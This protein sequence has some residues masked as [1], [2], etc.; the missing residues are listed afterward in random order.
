M[1]SRILAALA[2]R[3]SVVGLAVDDRVNGIT[4]K[5]H[6]H[7]QFDSASV[8]K[9]TILSALLR[10]LQQ[11]HRGLTAAQRKLATAMITVSDN[12]AASTLWAETGRPSLQH[13][14]DLAGMTETVLGPGGYWGLTLI[15]AHD[16][17]TLL[18]LLTSTN[19]VL[20]TAS[21]DYVLGL[22]AR[23]VSY[24]RW[25]VP[26]GAPTDVTVHVK[27]GWLPLPTHGWRINSIGSFSGPGKDY[28]IVVL[29]DDNPTMAYGVDTV[30][31]RRR[32]D[33]P[34]AEPRRGL[35]HPRRHAERLVGHSPTSRSRRRSGRIVSI[36]ADTRAAARAAF[37]DWVF[38]P[39]IGRAPRHLRDRE[40]RPS[41]PGG[42][43][44]AAMRRLAPWDGRTLVDLGCGTGFW[45]TGYARDAARV[46]GIEPDPALR[47]RAAAR[48]RRPAGGRGDARL[49]GAPAP[50]RPLRGRG[51]RQVRLLPRARQPTARRRA[52]HGRRRRA[53]RGLA[54]AGPGRQPDR[55]RQRL[56]VGP[57]RRAARRGVQGRRRSAPPTTSTRGGGSAAPPG[58]RSGHGG[59]LPAARI[60]RPC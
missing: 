39:N 41:T 53:G 28:M 52:G 35:G 55:R 45:L 34:C 40:P 9:V 15:T 27:N 47:A 31:G 17:L 57:V 13:F 33:Q 58:T 18:K 5:L 49:G 23:V 8:V 50:R 37:P 7:W 48:T 29:T 11:E 36:T 51:A 21:R 42:H 46:I 14:L 2:G 10:K 16:E 59:A 6:P 1:S 20:T 54:G 24:E 38:A 32:G 44:L 19:S 25:G 12:D 30:A 3:S 43:V 26:A 60:S 22:M 4:C 56:P